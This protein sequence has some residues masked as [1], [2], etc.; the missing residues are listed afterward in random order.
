MLAHGRA[1]EAGHLVVAHDMG[2]G[3]QHRFLIEGFA[4]ELGHDASA[5]KDQDAIG[6]R[7]HLRGIVA[8]QDDGD[9]LGREMRDDAVDLR[10]RPDVDAAGRLVE[11]QDARRRDQPLGQ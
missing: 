9:S 5:A 2:R 8:D 3:E 7:A 1:A 10:L 4:H 6:H 11:D